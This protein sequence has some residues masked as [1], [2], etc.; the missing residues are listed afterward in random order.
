MRYTF[1]YKYIHVGYVY[2]VVFVHT[3]L[4]VPQLH[5]ALVSHVHH[6]EKQCNNHSLYHC[7]HVLTQV[8]TCSEGMAGTRLLGLIVS[9]LCKEHTIIILLSLLLHL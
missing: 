2:I 5:P 3:L 4:Y 6:C 7:S 1:Q 8:H 9:P